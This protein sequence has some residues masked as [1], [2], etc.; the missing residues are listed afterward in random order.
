MLLERVPVSYDRNTILMSKHGCKTFV[1]PGTTENCNPQHMSVYFSF[2]CSHVEYH[3]H[4]LAPNTTDHTQQSKL[5]ISRL[6]YDCH[7]K[8]M[9]LFKSPPYTPY[10]QLSRLFHDSV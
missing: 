10:H 4:T 2:F 1:V 3:F 7:I 5:P 9:G 8:W 6:Y